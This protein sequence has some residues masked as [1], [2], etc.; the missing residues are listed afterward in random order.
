MK[1]IQCSNCH[2]TNSFFSMMII[3]KGAVKQQNSTPPALEEFIHQYNGKKFS[4]LGLESCHVFKVKRVEF[5]NHPDLK[6]FLP[7]TN[8][9]INLI[10]NVYQKQ[11][12][13]VILLNIWN[14]FVSLFL[15]ISLFFLA[16]G[17]GVT[18][19]SNKESK[20]C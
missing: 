9:N 3:K 15:F 13:N 4:S 12:I 1:H 18:R 7:P 10:C 14:L 20:T 16:R 11:N 5:L 17:R 19:D 8:Q 6:L 2:L